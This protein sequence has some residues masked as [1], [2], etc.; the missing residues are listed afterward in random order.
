M[1][2]SSSWTPSQGEKAKTES[3]DFIAIEE[4]EIEFRE[5]KTARL[6]KT[7]YQQGKNSRN[8]YGFPD[9]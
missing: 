5:V 8:L 3:A 2:G 4:T 9:F 1:P 7:D 6:C